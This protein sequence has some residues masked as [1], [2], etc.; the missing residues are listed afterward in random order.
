MYLKVVPAKILQ[1]HQENASH[2]SRNLHRLARHHQKTPRNAL[3]TKVLSINNNIMVQ[4]NVFYYII[5]YI[6]PNQILMYEIKFRHFLRSIESEVRFMVIFHNVLPHPIDICWTTLKGIPNCIVNG[7]ESGG[8]SNQTTY[9]THPWIFLNSTDH[10]KRYSAFS[11]GVNGLVFEG[12]AF[13]AKENSV[14]H[15]I[16]NE[17]G[18]CK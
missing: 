3:E 6:I 13:R 11:A 14:I 16:I 1:S 17:K 18:N 2:A 9:F 7:L 4:N 8:R 5:F 10:S 12:S 15:V